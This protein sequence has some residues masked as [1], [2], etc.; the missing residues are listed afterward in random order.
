[1][2]QNDAVLSVLKRVVYCMRCDQSGGK[3]KSGV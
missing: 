1:V 3:A 2:A